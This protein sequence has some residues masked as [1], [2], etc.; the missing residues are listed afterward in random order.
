M[1]VRCVVFDSELDEL[2]KHA[3]AYIAQDPNPKTR[4]EMAEVRLRCVA[5][6]DF[7]SIARLCGSLYRKPTS[8]SYDGDSVPISNSERPD[9]AGLWE[10]VSTAS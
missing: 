8:A 7:Q 9:F 10:V 4:S 5:H 1:R 3:Q 6:A 2:L